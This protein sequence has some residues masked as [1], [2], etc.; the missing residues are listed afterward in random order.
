MTSNFEVI[1][2]AAVTAV[3][4]FIGNISPATLAARLHGVD[5]RK[6]GSGNPGTTNVLRT[7]GKKAAAGTLLID[8][9]KGFLPALAAGY[10]ISDL[11][12]VLCGTAALLGHMWPVCFKF[13]GGKGVATGFGVALAIDWHVGV[14][15]LLCAVLG[16]LVTKRMSCGSIIAAISFPFTVYIFEVHNVPGAMQWEPAW[17]ACMG[18]LII[19]RHRSNIKRLVKGEE[20]PL[21]FLSKKQEESM[22]QKKDRK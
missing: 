13:Q 12:A 16:V 1:S 6:E 10:F 19:W 9:L 17:A 14:I 7:L 11:A 18:L 3:S 8:V 21:S 15:A 20:P 5:I 4:Y 2:L 22:K